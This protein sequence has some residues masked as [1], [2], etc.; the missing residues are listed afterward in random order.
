MH[1]N[2]VLYCLH[3]I[4]CL[5]PFVGSTI[6]HL[7][8]CHN[9]GAMTY[10]LLLKFDM[11]GVWCINAVGGVTAISATLFCYPNLVYTCVTLYIAMALVLLYFI[12]KAKS[13]KGRFFPLIPFGIFRFAFLVI[14]IIR[15]W[16][17]Q[18]SGES[19]AIIYYILMEQAAL[20]GGILNITRF[21]E[22][23]FPN[24]LDLC[25]NSHN[26]MHVFVSLCPILLHYGTML[27]LNWMVSFKCY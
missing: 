14:R 27:D 25:F 21:P 23:Y 13:A 8:M 16:Q 3:Y 7:F 26:I 18:P 22:R 10:S 1:I 12:L 15:L 5:S 9:S 4:G 2:P 6:Y 17:G 24:K 11:C 20:S 19:G